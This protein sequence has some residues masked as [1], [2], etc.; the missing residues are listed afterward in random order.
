[1]K[2]NI[3]A[4]CVSII[5]VVFTWLV[6]A[7]TVF[8]QGCEPNAELLKSFDEAI[9]LDIRLNGLPPGIGPERPKQ[10]LLYKL[11]RGMNLRDDKS[12][13]IYVKISTW[14]DGF[15]LQ[16]DP[17]LIASWK[18]ELARDKLVLE[19]LLCMENRPP[20]PSLYR[21]DFGYKNFGKELKS[22][23]DSPPPPQKTNC[24]RTKSPANT[25]EGGRFK[26]ASA[27]GCFRKSSK[28]RCCASR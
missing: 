7:D 28:S 18:S 14:Y 23:T 10:D 5:A 3:P 4:L 1:M 6:P 25:A 13:R 12:E 15:V 17:K 22:A 20:D 9:Q 21:S 16:T 8:A 27:T 26:Y 11:D 19:K 2:I 24:R